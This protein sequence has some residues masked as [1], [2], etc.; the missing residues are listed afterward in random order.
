MVLNMSYIK[1]LFNFTALNMS[2]KV[3]K[4]KNCLINKK[5]CC[6]FQIII[7]EVG[8]NYIIIEIIRNNANQ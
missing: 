8:S 6:I 4:I 5:M 1:I 7:D 2:H 3:F